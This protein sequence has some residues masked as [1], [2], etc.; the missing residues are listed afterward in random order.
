M[1]NKIGLFSIIFSFATL[2]FTTSHV[3]ASVRVHSYYKKSGTYV[4]THHRSNPDSR[5]SNN[6]SS[7]GNYNPYTGKKGT[8][9][10]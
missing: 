7:K 10:W 3:E 6:Y 1:K 9:N 5:K 2:L 8:K 4:T